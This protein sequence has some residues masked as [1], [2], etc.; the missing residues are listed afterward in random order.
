MGHFQGSSSQAC[1]RTVLKLLKG[2]AIRSM[3]STMSDEPI[4]F[5]RA[6]TPFSARVSSRA[7]SPDAPRLAERTRF[8]RPELKHILNIYG[9]MVIAGQWRDYA[10]DFRDE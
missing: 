5:N 3:L 9:R 1:Y 7:G 6:E 8:D 4:V 2:W 10:I